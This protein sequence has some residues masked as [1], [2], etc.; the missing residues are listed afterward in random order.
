[1]LTPCLK[2][3]R[4]ALLQLHEVAETIRWKQE[5]GRGKRRCPSPRFP[6][7]LGLYCQL[8]V[9]LWGHG[10]P[11][12]TLA[13]LTAAAD[14][15]GRFKQSCE[16]LTACSCRA[17]KPCRRGHAPLP[18]NRWPG[19]GRGWPF[20]TEQVAKARQ[21]LHS[22]LCQDPR[23]YAPSLIMNW[24]SSSSGVVLTAYHPSGKDQ[25]VG[26]SHGKGGDE[27]TSR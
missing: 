17:R 2:G 23:N 21:E 20:A 9:F 5:W 8:A 1:M 26:E 19:Q 18:V 22:S 25:V 24:L 16:S 14:W 27:A 7:S 6:N 15:G 3:L 4:N 12:S 11:R 13:P 10:P